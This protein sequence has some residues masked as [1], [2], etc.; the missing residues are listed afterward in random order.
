M[1]EEGSKRGGGINAIPVYT[2]KQIEGIRRACKVRNM[3]VP[4]AAAGCRKVMVLLSTSFT[5]HE[6]RSP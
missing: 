4:V 2:P 5:Q 3:H 1:S 6:Y